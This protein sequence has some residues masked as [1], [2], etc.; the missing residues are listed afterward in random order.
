MNAVQPEITTLTLT[1]QGVEASTKRVA[2]PVNVSAGELQA[3]NLAL[4]QFSS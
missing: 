3:I 4:N 1:P 2:G